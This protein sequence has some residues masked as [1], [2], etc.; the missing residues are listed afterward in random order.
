MYN[1]V[2]LKD[3]GSSSYYFVTKNCHHVLDCFGDRVV[4]SLNHS[5][6]S[7]DILSERCQV[8]EDLQYSDERQE[9]YVDK[10]EYWY[11]DDIL[12]YQDSSDELALPTYLADLW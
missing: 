12:G 10:S 6:N 2:Y 1:L 11:Y 3:F 7:F 5:D 9:W 8:S 4:V